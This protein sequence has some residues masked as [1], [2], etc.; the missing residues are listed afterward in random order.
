VRGPPALDALP[1]AA[2]LDPLPAALRP[3]PVRPAGLGLLRD[4]R[5]AGG[6][7]RR[8]RHGSAGRRRG[9]R[10][11]GRRGRG[12]GGWSWGGAG[13]EAGGG[14]PHVSV[15]STSRDPASW[16]IQSCF[17]SIVCCLPSFRFSG[18]SR[19]CVVPENETTSSKRT[20]PSTRTLVCD[21]S[22]GPLGHCV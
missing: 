16:P 1:F 17:A 6:S 20:P 4:E 18:I 15:A 22:G 2:S 21:E 12:A 5:G 3:A 13:G 11:R 8:H 9:G 19:V 10:G 14:D 7:G